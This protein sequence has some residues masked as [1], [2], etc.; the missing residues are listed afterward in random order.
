MNDIAAWIAP[1]ATVI[2]AVMTAANLGARITDWGFVVFTVGS[3]S[4]DD[5]YRS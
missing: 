2:A 5:G 3:T 1:A 4:L